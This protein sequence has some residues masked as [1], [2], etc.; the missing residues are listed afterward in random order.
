[1]IAGW[2]A[3]S[4]VQFLA[5]DGDRLYRGD[6]AGNVSPFVTL[7]AAVQS[8]TRVPP[9]FSINGAS[10]GDIIATARDAT[11]GNWNVFRL[12][13]PFGAA[14]L[15]Q[16][17]STSFG[18]G[19]IAFAPG[20]MYAVNDTLSPIRVAK[21]DTNNFSV[22][23]N[24]STGVSVTGGGGIAYDT[25]AAVFYLTDYTNNRL[26]S[27]TP[28]NNASVIGN[29][30][31]GFLNNGLEFLNGTLYGALRQDSPGSVIRVGSFDTS[32]G[33]FTANTLINGVSG[34][35]TGFVTVPGPAG[36]GV[37]ALAGALALRRR[38]GV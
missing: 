15:T 22:V 18:V 26:L 31:F 12:D 35:G 21:L 25:A 4:P 24:Y 32:T 2:A 19:S 33:I 17:G 38:R 28:G 11:S 27:W 9:G 1:M 3:G 5:T 37:L 29:I 36:A 7:S 10:G 30:G 16:I 14:T 34:N 20:G 6:L 23:Q 13:D 8:L